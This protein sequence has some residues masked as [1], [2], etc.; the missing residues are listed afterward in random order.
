MLFYIHEPN[1]QTSNYILK[2]YNY[3]QNIPNHFKLFLLIWT[4]QKYK[5]CK[6]D[7]KTI[8]L[9]C[10]DS[11]IRSWGVMG[12]QRWVRAPGLWVC[13]DFRVQMKTEEKGSNSFGLFLGLGSFSIKT[14]SCG[15]LFLFCFKCTTQYGFLKLI[16]FCAVRFI[17]ELT[18]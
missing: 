3:L 16:G 15:L 7:K 5:T 18:W 4:K 11:F 12:V 8:H 2:E 14:I 10:L 9:A 13:W 1:N 17:V 6:W